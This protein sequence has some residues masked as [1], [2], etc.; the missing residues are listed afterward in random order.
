MRLSKCFFAIKLGD[1]SELYCSG[2]EPTPTSMHLDGLFR[3]RS[4][5]LRR[6][7]TNCDVVWISSLVARLDLTRLCAHNGV[8]D[9]RFVCVCIL[10]PKWPHAVVYTAL[11]DW[12]EAALRF[13]SNPKM[14]SLVE[15][16]DRGKRKGLRT[17]SNLSGI[18]FSTSIVSLIV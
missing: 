6:C 17:R 3:I 16:D 1:V 10:M 15:C 5:C 11:S 13:S 9:L 4:V 7:L 14:L 18:F 8:Y 12:N 2:A